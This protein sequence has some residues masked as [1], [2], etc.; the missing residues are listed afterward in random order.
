MS[1]YLWLRI[2]ENSLMEMETVYLPNTTKEI[3][4]QTH[5]PIQKGQTM[6]IG[7]GLASNIS[8]N[9]VRFIYAEGEV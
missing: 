2:N 9:I 4:L 1:P 7:Y 3:T 8:E 6:T 5:I